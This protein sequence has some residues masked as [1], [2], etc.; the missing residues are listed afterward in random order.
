MSPIVKVVIFS[1]SSVVYLFV[2]SKL[3]GKKQIAQLDF[4]DYV[5]G[6]SIGSIAAEMATDT[7]QNP[8]YYYIIAMGIFFLFDVFVTLIARKGTGLKHFF[9]GKPATVIYEGKLNYKALNKCGIDVNDVISMCREKGYFNINDVA[10]AVFETSGKLSVLPKGHMR[11][12]VAEDLRQLNIEQA[13]LPIYLVVDGEVSYSSL[14][15]I[16]KDEKWLMEKLQ[17]NSTKE[18]KQILLAIYD[19]QTRQV[20]LHKKIKDV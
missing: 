10:Y 15:E 16:D 4:I 14:S 11:P 13:S 19:E 2:L 20:V 1:L 6:I 8:F 5:M 12:T 9:K 7:S 3:L 18:L 17:I